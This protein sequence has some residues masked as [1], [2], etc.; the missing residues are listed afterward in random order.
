[1]V[2]RF[3]TTVSAANICAAVSSS[4]NSMPSKTLFQIEILR[5]A[6][7]IADSVASQAVNAGST[8]AKLP[9]SPHSTSRM[10]PMAVPGCGVANTM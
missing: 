4:R 9:P 2:I 3:L 1:M 7:D 10:A 8:S 5:P 6:A